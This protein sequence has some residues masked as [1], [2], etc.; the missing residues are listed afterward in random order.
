VQHDLE[1]KPVTN[2]A[3]AIVQ[4]PVDVEAVDQVAVAS[5][6]VASPDTDANTSDANTSDVSTT[7]DNNVSKGETEAP[8]GRGR[9]S[10]RHVRAAGQRRKKDKDEKTTSDDADDANSVQDELQFDEPIASA[11]SQPSDAQSAKVA[12]KTASPEPIQK[13]IELDASV[14]STATVITNAEATV[15]AATNAAVEAAPTAAV[16]AAPATT[17]EAAPATTVEAAPATTVEAAPAT[18]VEATPATTVEAAPA[19]AV[20]ATPTAAVEAAPATTVEAAPA[21][22]VE[23][24]PTETAEATPTAIVEAT[25]VKAQTKAKET[26]ARVPYVRVAVK[27]ASHPM[28]TPAKVDMPSEPQIVHV[29]SDDLRGNVGLGG[30]SAVVANSKSQASSPMKNT[31]SGS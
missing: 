23:A 11:S 3:D 27:T 7:D 29:I 14:T 16:E 4:A 10:P 26:K 19:T 25:P 17:V 24:T 12:S 31:T 8:R 30:K 15:E 20:E 6:T 18:A 9:R 28:A 5:T 22:T 21:T 13:E 2:V 1:N